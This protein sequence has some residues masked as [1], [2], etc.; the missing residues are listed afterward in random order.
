[1]GN[2]YLTLEEQDSEKI[3]FMERMLRET[4]FVPTAEVKEL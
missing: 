3:H 2:N 4:G 1:V